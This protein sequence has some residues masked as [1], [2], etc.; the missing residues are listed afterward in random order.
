MKKSHEG[1]HL[2]NK[3]VGK[4]SFSLVHALRKK[5]GIKKIGHAGTLDPFA[6]G[7]MI[8]LVGKAFTTKADSFINQDK[9][10]EATLR[11]GIATTTYD[12]EGEITSESA[13][14]PTLEQIKK[15]L[16]K[17]QGT[18]QQIPPMFSAKKVQGKKLYELARKGI[19]IK[20]EPVSLTVTTELISYS[21]P[22]LSLKISCSKGTYIRSIA[23]DL[24]QALGCGAHLKELTRTRC[25]PY[26]LKDCLDGN[27]LF[28]ENQ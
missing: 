23:H 27:T 11:L 2:I 6:T 15:E 9:E 24:G 5:T 12:P 17:F 3:P 22:E 20:R 25:G 16:T 4:T 14:I 10:Y 7:V 18:I 13:L 1:I 21:Y 8:L 19:E 26:L 28:Q